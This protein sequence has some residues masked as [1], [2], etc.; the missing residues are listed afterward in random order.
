MTTAI[1]RTFKTFSLLLCIACFGVLART[2]LAND[3]QAV[4]VDTF[5]DSMGINLHHV[6]ND[7]REWL[8]ELGFRHIRDNSSAYPGSTDESALT[9]LYNTFGIKVGFPARTQWTVAQQV[10]FAR[11]PFVEWV[12][13]INEPDLANPPV[14]YNGL[15]DLD[16]GSTDFDA[17]IAFQNDLYAAIKADP[18]T[19]SLPVL[20]CPMA[21][22]NRCRDIA[23]L[24]FDIGSIHYYSG[25]R[26]PIGGMG[27]PVLESVLDDAM[28]L[29]NPADSNMPL[30][31]SEV[32]YHTYINQPGHPGISE[33][34]FGKYAPRIFAEYFKQGIKCTY[35]YQLRDDVAPANPPSPMEYH[36]GLVDSYG[37][38]RQPYWRIK[39]MISLLSDTT[40]WNGS[41]WQYPNFTPGAL[42]YTLT[43]NTQN[44]RQLL[45]QKS[46][47]QFYL[48]LWQEVSVYDHD[49]HN[50]ITNPTAPVTL[51]IN[52]PIDRVETYLLDSTT[53][54]ASYDNARSMTL[55]VP[56]EIMVVRLIP[57]TISFPWYQQDIGSVGTNGYSWQSGDTFTVVG[58]GQDM[59]STTDQFRYVYQKFH[60]DGSIVAQVQ[61]M[62]NTSGSARAG[63]M[64]RNSTDADSVHASM[65]LL[66]GEERK[67]HYRN[68]VN[69]NGIAIATPP[70]SGSCWLKLSRVGDQFNGYYSSDGSNW[71]LAGTQT[72]P[73]N[74]EILVGFAVTSFNNSQLNTGVIQK[75][76]LSHQKITVRPI[77]SIAHEGTS[78]ADN[79]AFK[80]KRTGYIYSPLPV[81]YTLE[82]SASYN[83]DYTSTSQVANF[84][85]G[86]DTMY[87]S[88]DQVNDA[89]IESDKTVVLKVQNGANYGLGN[90]WQ[91]QATLYDDEKIGT[92]ES[93]SVPA[94]WNADGQPRSSVSIDTSKA[95]P[96]GG[97]QSLR[98]TYN[99]NGID[100]WGNKIRC[101]FSTPQDWQWATKLKLHF[102]SPALVSG[103]TIYVNIKN[104]DIAPTSSAIAN[105]HLAP[106]SDFQDVTIDLTPYARDQITSL[107]FYLDG[108]EFDGNSSGG[109]N[110]QFNLDNISLFNPINVANFEDSDLSHWS[111]STFSSV[112]IET[113]TLDIAGGKRAL[114]WTFNAT[115]TDAW[116][117]EVGFNPPSPQDWTSA[118]FLKFRIA[119]TSTNLAGKH[120]F[121]DIRNDGVSY[122]ASGI[123][124]YVFPADTQYHDV[125]IPLADVPR[126]LVTQLA[127]YVYGLEFS[128]G[129][130][131]FLMDNIRI[132]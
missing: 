11:N 45:L 89:N 76:Y 16:S 27:G 37:N 132:K 63:L 32:G 127:F 66:P 65:F 61:S 43:G 95:D 19:A 50:D 34:A 75:T 84:P 102:A 39:N 124:S 85:A 79:A 119:A 15:T 120:I 49:N 58:S 96:A 31:V 1:I 46:N 123:G 6:D 103:K 128:T 108:T 69:T 107:F 10:A 59:F 26:Q 121:L 82:G 40:S 62:D 113:A 105:F 101:D 56:D 73:M 116:A 60:G 94:G 122:S 5:I 67:F 86:V 99:D 129:S 87:V 80:I 126:D 53:A 44:V 35:L 4:S 88:I 28:W 57:R 106:H 13:G 100:R 78:P 51:N 125:S 3:V 77:D 83:T 118:Q 104:N 81:T 74:W 98:W 47:G 71:T 93:A 22:V 109:I 115:G 41:S 25:G 54:N 23:N 42:D 12:E 29:K 21:Y 112:N 48:L 114:R 7:E 14:S 72:I 70:T 55:N 20:T 111:T 24:S 131:T 130:H 8:A 64:M 33:L 117:N 18:Q 91:A 97:S 30:I 36:F 38:K 52:T 17:T 9:E 90:R 68:T 110:Y 92:F 2:S